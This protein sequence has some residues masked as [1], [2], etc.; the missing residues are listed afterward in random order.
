MKLHHVAMVELRPAP[1]TLRR[2]SM[3]AG[4]GVTVEVNNF[5]GPEDVTDKPDVDQSITISWGRVAEMTPARVC[6]SARLEVVVEPVNPGEDVEL[7]A[8]DVRAT[9]R[10]LSAAA[11][12]LAVTCQAKADVFSP[13]P[14][15]YLEPQNDVEARTLLAAGRIALPSLGSG[16]ARLAPGG[17]RGV[18]F[19]KL[20]TDRPQGVA[21]LA[22]ALSAEHGVAKLHEL[23]RVFE[24]AFAVAGNRLVEP[25]TKFL[26]SHQWELGYTRG[27]VRHWIK[28]LRDS[29]THA[30]LKWSSAVLLDPDVERFLPRIEQAA[31]D[32]LFNKDHW[33]RS[34]SA[35]LDRWAFR[36][37]VRRDGSAIGSDGAVLQVY[38]AWDHFRMF[39]L[40]EN[41]TMKSMIE[42]GW[43]AADWYS[44][45]GPGSSDVA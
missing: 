5:E 2:W 45:E 1:T 29:A 28:D 7:K 21:L 13:R 35:R 26:E 14:Y 6:V 32:V 38:D 25:L 34:D 9:A 43:V 30:D 23:A 8:D 16:G 22:A 18:D 4:C 24:N 19:S 31:Y 40:N 12:Q 41:Y 33:H 39:K 11:S 10:G 17:H 36:S 44:E 37:M 42:H 27:E 20:L 3:D 15:L